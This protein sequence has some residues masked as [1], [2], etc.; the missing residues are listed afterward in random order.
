VKPRFV[1]LICTLLLFL[2]A[3]IWLRGEFVHDQLTINMHDHM[4]IVGSFPNH[5]DLILYRASNFTG[6]F[7]DL[8]TRAKFVPS[9]P[10]F[11]QCRFVATP[12]KFELALPWWLPTIFLLGMIGYRQFIRTRTRNR[13]TRNR[14]VHCGYD[15]RATPDKCPEC[16]TAISHPLH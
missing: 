16:G 10:I 14:C 11:W 13:Q 9:M 12:N 1:L 7:L 3:A 4:F 2:L 15:L 6:K 5:I 8:T